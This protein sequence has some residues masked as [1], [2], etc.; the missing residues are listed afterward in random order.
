MVAR[1]NILL[2][3]SWALLL[4]LAGSGR[5]TVLFREDF[6]DMSDWTTYLPEG[7]G[8]DI[9]DGHA[10]IWGDIG[11]VNE[12]QEPQMP[13]M[14]RNIAVDVSLSTFLLEIDYR[15]RSLSSV[16]YATNAWVMFCDP[17][18]G[19]LLG[20]VWLAFGSTTDTGWN[21][22][23][24]DV[25][26]VLAS[27]AVIE[28]RLGYS[29]PWVAR[30]DHEVWFDNLTIHYWPFVWGQEEPSQITILSTKIQELT[31]RISYL[32][33]SIADL[34]KGHANLNDS[35]VSLK[36]ATSTLES[37]VESDN[38][39]LADAV[40]GVRKALEV[41]A[42]DLDISIQELN[43]TLSAGM[44]NQTSQIRSLAVAVSGLGDRLGDL[45]SS[46]GLLSMRLDAGLQQTMEL[47]ALLNLT[48][49]R[50]SYDI[51]TA[52]EVA[53]RDLEGDLGQMAR[54]TNLTLQELDVSIIG[55]EGQLQGIG[56]Q[57]SAANALVKDVQEALQDSIQLSSADLSARMDRLESR[58]ILLSA[59]G[60]L[61]LALILI[62]VLAGF[63]LRK[64]GAP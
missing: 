9:Q 3:L 55:V 12:R 39:M 6:S 17:D 1:C 25:S 61:L 53:T 15:A 56:A 32:E 2:V 50:A 64:K 16:S 23:V 48:L 46:V 19:E 63:V 44:R 26:T 18:T 36:T 11:S 38:Q 29:D 34:A 60:F 31:F 45:N 54:S 58:T 59:I 43:A 51:R 22:R 14:V 30:Y 7:Y 27:H 47:F 42:G 8:A 33:G 57:L 40:S 4:C 10:H 37:T 5:C 62:A 49:Y 21:H 13:R 20:I 28:I 52:V 41:V 24:V 35:L